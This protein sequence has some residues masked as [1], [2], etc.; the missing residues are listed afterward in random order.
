[1]TSTAPRSEFCS[2]KSIKAQSSPVSS[3]DSFVNRKLRDN[4]YSVDSAYNTQTS[5]DPEWKP[6]DISSFSIYKMI[7]KGAFSK[8]YLCRRRVDGRIFALKSM[9]KDMLLKMRQV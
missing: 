7:G 9:R 8:V 3:I 6:S 4:E 5:I 1:M 2:G